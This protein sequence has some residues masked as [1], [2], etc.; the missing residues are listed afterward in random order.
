MTGWNR[1]PGRWM[2][3]CLAVGCGTYG[4]KDDDD[5]DDTGPEDWQ[6]VGDW[7]DDTDAD[8]DADADGDA[9]SGEGDADADTDADGDSDTDTDGDS[10]TD[11]DT[12]TDVE[13]MDGVGGL[14]DYIY[15]VI[16][17][18]ACFGYTA[19]EQVQ[20]T[21][22]VRFHPPS[23]GSWLSWRPEPGRCIRDV[24]ITEL[25]TAGLDLGGAITLSYGS[26]NWMLVRETDTTGST[27]KSSGM[28]AE[29]WVNGGSYDIEVDG[30]ADIA[31]F[32]APGVAIAVEGFTDIQPIGILNGDAASAYRERISAENATFTWAPAGVGDGVVFMVAG[33]DPAT[34]ETRGIITCYAA[35]TGS[36]TIPAEMFYTPTPWSLFDDLVIYFHRYLLTETM[37]PID[38][39][40]I[41]AVTKKGGVGT[42]TLV[43]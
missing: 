40:T 8:T 26:M 17:C 31:G 6:G 39:S 35:D 36:F 20:V 9:D 32:E 25:S 10:D 27:Y 12:D 19:A 14:V 41:Q 30:T 5:D 34:G 7:H 2:W 16:A 28:T 38:G 4:L 1:M 42:A 24:S 23:S 11:S 33:S 29:D 13:P 22:A 21:A 3:L 43:E 18:P 15:N 37:S